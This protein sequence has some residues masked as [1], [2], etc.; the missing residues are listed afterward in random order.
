MFPQPVLPRIQPMRKSGT[1]SC[2][3]EQPRAAPTEELSTLGPE[4]TSRGRPAFLRYGGENRRRSGSLQICLIPIGK[5]PA[6][7][8]VDTRARVVESAT[9]NTAPSRR[10]RD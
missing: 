5:N 1:A 7:Q 2:G 3:R 8:N 4:K 6:S 9:E 10:C